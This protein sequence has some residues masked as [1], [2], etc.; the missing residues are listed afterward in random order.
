MKH[1][2]NALESWIISGAL[3]W[4]IWQLWSWYGLFWYL[5]AY[6]LLMIID[7]ARETQ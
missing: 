2:M 7:R 3:G 6:M 1:F 4:V 5:I